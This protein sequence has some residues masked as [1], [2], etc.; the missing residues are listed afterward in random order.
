MAIRLWPRSS[1]N[2]ADAYSWVVLLITLHLPLCSFRL[3]AGPW[4]W[5]RL[6][7][8]TAVVHA[9]LVCWC[10][11]VSCCVPFVVVRPEIRCVAFGYGTGVLFCFEV[12]AA[13][14]DTGS[15]MCF[16]GLLVSFHRALCSLLMSSG[17]SAFWSVWTRRTVVLRDGGRVLRRRGQRHVH[18]AGFAGYDASV[19]CS[20]VCRQADD[21]RDNGWLDVCYAVPGSTVDTYSASALRLNEFPHFPV[22]FG[23]WT[24]GRFS[25]CSPVNGQNYAQS[26][27]QERDGLPQEGPETG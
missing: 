16:A 13:L 14:F 20:L 17:C 5:P 11:S 23:T 25:S 1:S 19:L 24:C 21:A 15:G 2:A 26:M 18:M 27:L 12:Q 7:S 3:S 4:W 6:S 22:V 10:A 9:T 8:I